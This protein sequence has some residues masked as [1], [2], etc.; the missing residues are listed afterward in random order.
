MDRDDGLEGRVRALVERPACRGP[1]TAAE[2]A[3]GAHLCWKNA[4]ALLADARVLVTGGRHAR[5]LS[6][7]VLAL[8]ELAKP[9]LLWQLDT[10]GSA[11]E[12]RRFWKESFARHSSKQESIGAYGELLRQIGA[13]IYESFLPTPVVEALDRLKQWGFYVDCVDDRFQAPDELELTVLPMLDPV[14][15][16]AEER[17]DSFAKLHASVVLSEWCYGRR[18]EAA[19]PGAL[20]RL[21]VAEVDDASAVV[22]SYASQYSRS[23]PPDYLTFYEACRAS[24]G[25]LPEATRNRVFEMTRT[26]CS[27]RLPFKALPTAA[28]RAFLMMKLTLGALTADE[29]FEEP[30]SEENDEGV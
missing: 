4:V 24:L 11:T 3:R 14:F 18:F 6:L 25:H 10:S 9:P 23:T 16:F 26:L 17:A 5:A 2:V 8:E 21:P 7:T 13:G 28:A 1:V 29:I 19:V 22:L 15:A 20:P 27:L 12:W 30:D